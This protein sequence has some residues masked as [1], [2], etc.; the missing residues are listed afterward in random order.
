[1]ILS[2]TDLERRIKQR[3]GSLNVTSQLTSSA[4][5]WTC[6]TVWFAASSCWRCTMILQST[7]YGLPTKKRLPSNCQ[8]DRVYYAPVGTKK[9]L[10]VTDPSRQQRMRSTFGRSVIMSVAVSKWVWL[11]WFC[12]PSGEGGR[13][14]LPR[15]RAVSADVSSNQ[16]YRSIRRWHFRVS[17]RQCSGTSRP[18][19]HPAAAA[20]TRLHCLWSWP[21]APYNSPDLNPVNYKIWG[22][23]QQRVYKC[24]GPNLAGGRPGA[25]NPYPP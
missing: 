11:N 20:D 21:L 4:T 8:N 19:H 15:C 5:D 23:M 14:V 13:P 7:S 18:R 2:Y 9:R 1:M 6:F 16:T 3:C 12:R 25:P 22:V 24:A 17:T 10:T